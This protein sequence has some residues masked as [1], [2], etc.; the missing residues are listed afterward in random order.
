MA[1]PSGSGMVQS[2]L[3]TM[4]GGSRRDNGRSVLRRELAKRGRDPDYVD[5]D[6]YALC[7][8]CGHLVEPPSAGSPMRREPTPGPDMRECPACGT[9]GLADLRHTPTAYSLSAL[10]RDEPNFPVLRALGFVA[11]LAAL[12]LLGGPVFLDILDRPGAVDQW[13]RGA[14]LLGMLVLLVIGFLPS[15]RVKLDDAGAGAGRPRRWRL[16]GAGQALG[17]LPWGARPV[18]GRVRSEG[19]ELL[20][21]PLSGRPCV[22]YEVAVRSDDDP[23]ASMSSWTLLEQDN[24]DFH[25]GEVEVERGGA[26]LSL[27]RRLAWRGVL[28][29]QEAHVKRFMRMRGLLDV[30]EVYV[31]ETI[32]AAGDSCSV[33]AGEDDAPA[34]VCA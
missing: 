28:G 29:K 10:E 27:T 6:C 23:S 12:V 33:V 1:G 25:V 15:R 19:G 34:R 13:F 17:S 8:A 4:R 21:A 7:M 9:R 2:Y 18:R 26:L 30:E 32:V 16:A 11:S 24:V 22:A 20:R 31:Y 3:R 14:L 5:F